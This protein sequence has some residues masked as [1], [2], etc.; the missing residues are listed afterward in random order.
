MKRAFFA[1]L[2]AAAALIASCNNN[3]GPEPEPTPEPEKP[4]YGFNFD[5]FSIT[6]LGDMSGN[7]KT[8]FVVQM[9]AID[10]I[11]DQSPK[12]VAPAK[13]AAKPAPFKT[14]F[15]RKASHKFD[16]PVLPLR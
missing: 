14:N 11:D 16:T 12:S 7:G 13:A 3:N 15:D 10:E 4:F 9:S 8:Q 5:R 1:F 2:I 6:N